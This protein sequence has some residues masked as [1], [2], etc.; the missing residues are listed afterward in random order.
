VPYPVQVLGTELLLEFIAGPDGTA[1]PRLAEC[2]L[3]GSD[4]AGLWE[5]LVESMSVLARLGFAHGDLSA[6][7]LLLCRDQLI[8]I[9]VPQ[10]VDVVAN[11]RGAEFLDRDAAN[12]GRWFAM[13]G[14]SG[15][16]SSV[17]SPDDLAGF[18]RAEAGLT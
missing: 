1:A 7:N 12:V 16:H 8:M 11:P 5:Q 3:R 13:R 6:Y 18:L 17:P 14:L 15:Y 10:V 9:D 2:G 4:L